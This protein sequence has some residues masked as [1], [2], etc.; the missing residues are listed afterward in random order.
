MTFL[1]I[2]SVNYERDGNRFL[3]QH[4]HVI[5]AENKDRANAHIEV[6]LDETW[7]EPAYFGHEYEVRDLPGVTM[8]GEG[9]AIE[10]AVSETPII[11]YQSPSGGIQGSSV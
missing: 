11:I 8:E 2:T 4:V 10:Y 9:E 6:W 5:R 1:I 7:A 3:L